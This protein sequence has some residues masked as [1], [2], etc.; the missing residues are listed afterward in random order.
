[1]YSFEELLQPTIESIFKHADIDTSINLHEIYKFSEY[2]WREKINEQYKCTPEELV[3]EHDYSESKITENEMIGCI[4][5]GIDLTKRDIRKNTILHAACYYSF[6]NV[7]KLLIA[8]N[9]IDINALSSGKITPVSYACGLLN[10]KL[11]KLLIENGADITIEDE[12]GENP[13]DDARMWNHD[14][15]A[16]YLEGFINNG[17]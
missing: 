2:M 14:E 9:E 15:M 13:L 8:R 6:F 12:W 1:M 7:C 17:K 4:Y 3:C 5:A 11:V 10:Y 16:K